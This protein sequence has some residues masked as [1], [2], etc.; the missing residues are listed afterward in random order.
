MR[1]TALVVALVGFLVLMALYGAVTVVYSR[2]SRMGLS[3][4]YAPELSAATQVHIHDVNIELPGGLR[5]SGEG[6]K[7]G[8]LTWGFLKLPVS[9]REHVGKLL[10]FLASVGG[11]AVWRLVRTCGERSFSMTIGET[12][13]FR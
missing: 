4:R 13:S 11:V 9:H 3:R 1:R 2:V 5:V 10:L 6:Q 7:T 8:T 12:I